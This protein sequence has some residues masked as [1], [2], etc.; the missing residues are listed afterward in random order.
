MW[1]TTP[2]YI[3]RL[4]TDGD[5]ED[6]AG[7]SIGYVQVLDP[8]IVRIKTPLDFLKTPGMVDVRTPRLRVPCSR[9]PRS[10]SEPNNPSVAYTPRPTPSSTTRTL[11]DRRW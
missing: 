3:S 4:F 9:Y 8:S 2:L 10:R 1:K 6:D 5:R 11:V 7:I